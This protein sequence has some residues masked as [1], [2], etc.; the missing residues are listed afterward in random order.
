M[1]LFLKQIKNNNPL[2]YDLIAEKYQ[3]DVFIDKLSINFE[4]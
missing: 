3:L 2:I 4:D 1:V